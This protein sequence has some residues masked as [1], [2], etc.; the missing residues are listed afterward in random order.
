MLSRRKWVYAEAIREAIHTL[1]NDAWQLPPPAA[2]RIVRHRHFTSVVLFSIFVAADW[3]L[4]FILGT[5]AHSLFSAAQLAMVVP[6][7][8]VAAV[9]PYFVLLIQYSNM[10]SIG[11][12]R[13]VASKYLNSELVILPLASLFTALLAGTS[14]IVAPKAALDSAWFMMAKYLLALSWLTAI[15]S[16]V[17]SIR[18]IVQSMHNL[19]FTRAR[20][21]TIRE[22]LRAAYASLCADLAHQIAMQR[23]MESLE[24]LGVAPMWTHQRQGI[25]VLAQQSGHIQDIDLHAIARASARLTAH[26]SAADRQAQ[27]GITVH[28]GGAVHKDDA[29]AFVPLGADAPQDIAAL[30]A[31]A[32][33]ITKRP[34]SPHIDLRRALDEFK[35]PV[36]AAIQRSDEFA[37]ESFFVEY[38]RIADAYSALGIAGG[39]E[40]ALTY[41]DTWSLLRF[42]ES[43][44]QEILRAAARNS[45]ADFAAKPIYYT[46]RL[47]T[48]ALAADDAILFQSLS[49]V[50]SDC[51]YHCIRAGNA[52]GAY[53]VITVISELIDFDLALKFGKVQPDAAVGLL[54]YFESLRSTI[55]QMV[56]HTLALGSMQHFQGPFDLFRRLL[57]HFH[58]NFD[59]S[60]L[61]ARGDA[62]A[63]L[64]KLWDFDRA[65][66]RH[67]E[68]TM[69]AI[70]SYLI[71]LTRSGQC[72][73]EFAHRVLYAIIRTGLQPSLVFHWAQTASDDREFD[74]L[75]K[76]DEPTRGVMSEEPAARPRLVCLLVGLLA[77]IGKSTP[78][79]LGMS[80]FSHSQAKSLI[81]EL[82]SVD[83]VF[84]WALPS[85]S[86]ID[87]ENLASAIAESARKYETW[88]RSEIA[89]APLSPEH[90][91]KF[92][93]E[94]A[95][96]YGCGSPFRE[97]I[98]VNHRVVTDPGI[99]ETRFA[100]DT[101]VDREMFINQDRI[102]YLNG[103]S[104]AIADLAAEETQLAI[105]QLQSGGMEVQSQL[106]L[107][108]PDC[109][110]QAIA[111]LEK[112]GYRP[113]LLLVA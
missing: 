41:L 56:R 13:R 43:D 31:Q 36:I 65:H 48:H 82:Q 108:V 32:I 33:R 77:Q 27:L 30:V 35:T 87:I 51:F 70:V 72:S 109:C 75:W 106:P 46:K 63:A 3:R 92:R 1:R 61:N 47:L 66:D 113:D 59:G 28:L 93:D 71:D 10:E 12:A 64:Q 98:V 23:L 24:R 102:T 110:A 25:P 50:L 54:F 22:I 95:E 73:P 88:L 80:A 15:V 29:I 39:K 99:A 45:D 101:L 85:H 49:R 21:G 78:I 58:P 53:Q 16:L 79:D 17:H 9:I 34:I 42:L 55:A 112:L 111:Y 14:A 94:V 38:Q 97:L 89:N 44:I 52:R 91:Q 107:G 104:A 57:E 40:H 83:A 7:C 74:R 20:A 26:P 62:H 5:D 76:Y 90:I 19:D 4:H 2:I 69:P 100:A 6:T 84:E 105:A 18:F 67:V 8:L 60:M 86:T 37:V 96:Y 103:G 11:P 81:L 68:H